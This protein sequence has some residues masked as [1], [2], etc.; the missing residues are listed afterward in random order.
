MLG[1]LQTCP[2]SASFNPFTPCILFLLRFR[3][4]L[5]WQGASNFGE[6]S[7]YTGSV[8]SSTLGSRPAMPSLTIDIPRGEAGTFLYTPCTPHLHPM[9]TS[10]VHHMTP[11]C[12]PHVH[13]HVHPRWSLLTLARVCPCTIQKN[14]C[15]LACGSARH[16]KRVSHRISEGQMQGNSSGRV[17][18]ACVCWTGR[19]LGRGVI[20][21][22]I[23]GYVYTSTCID[24]CIRH[25]ADT[26]HDI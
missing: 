15:D 13:L 5:H 1:F 20:R 22:L 11:P 2:C 12:T 21:L 8:A 18:G 7:P 14:T 6:S 19:H 3:F 24:A 26:I 16:T 25:L 9:Y 10:H 17:W 4:S 23:M